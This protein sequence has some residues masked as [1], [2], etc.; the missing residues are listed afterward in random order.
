MHC[1]KQRFVDTKLT[2]DRLNKVIT[3]LQIS[4]FKL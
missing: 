4:A 2:Y 3:V 1:L